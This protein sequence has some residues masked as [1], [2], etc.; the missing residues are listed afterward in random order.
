VG[1]VIVLYVLVSMVTAGN[2]SISQIVAAKD[3][4]LAEAAR[5]FL[6]QTGYTLIAVAALLSTGSAINATLYGAA[7]ISYIIA[8]DGE[9][10]KVLEHKI[11]NRPIEG[12]LITSAVT[13][14]MANLLDL[15]SI[16]L[17]GSSG[18]LIIFAFINV[19]NIRLY[20]KT[21]SQI[22]ISAIGAIA[23]LTAFGALLWQI[24]ESTPSMLWLLGAMLVTAFAIEAIYR[25]IASRQILLSN[26]KDIVEKR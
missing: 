21:N 15:S 14:M 26:L 20:R 23:C 22:W 16:S 11:W 6:G 12:L 17:M 9:L 3:Y 24:A 10:P 5:P 4:A 7:R 13:L 1:F 25:K 19:A 8:K 18:F 2:L